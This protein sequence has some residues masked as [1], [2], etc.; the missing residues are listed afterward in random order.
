M[1]RQPVVVPPW[2]LSR[3]LQSSA[4]LEAHLPFDYKAQGQS[5]RR[6]VIERSR[7]R[8]GAGKGSPPADP[9]VPA[10]EF[11][12]I[13]QTL[14]GAGIP[15]APPPPCG[16]RAAP[17]SFFGFA[18]GGRMGHSFGGVAVFGPVRPSPWAYGPGYPTR[19]GAGGSPSPAQESGDKLKGQYYYT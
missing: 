12:F 3:H 15:S 6:A 8:A 9:P 13:S 16:L 17:V 2:C 7:R 1:P 5:Q 11:C 19:A 10:S 4:F 14:E 18:A